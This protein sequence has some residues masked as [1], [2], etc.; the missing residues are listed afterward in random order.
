MYSHRIIV[1]KSSR[2]L[3]FASSL[4]AN[5]YKR[6]TNK[7]ETIIIGGGPIGTSIALHLAW[8]RGN[9][10]GVLV[11]ERD[12][13]FKTC[14][15]M[16]S[17][18]GIRQQ[19][20]A[21][22][23]IQMS[24]Y[25][26]LFLKDMERLKVEDED[27]PNVQFKEN[28]YLFLGMGAQNIAILEE[29]NRMQR[30]CGIDWMH[31]VG[32][33]ELS[34][35][36]PWLNT[37][38]LEIGSYSSK[39]EGYFD[40]WSLVHSMKKK[41]ISLGVEF[42]EG[43]VVGA[44]TETDESKKNSSD[45]F[46][47]SKINVENYGGDKKSV[48]NELVADVFVNAAGAWAGKLVDDIALATSC[49]EAITPLPVSPRKRCIFNIHCPGLLQ[50]KFPVPPINTP[51]VIDPSGVYFRPEGGHGKFIAGVSPLATNDPN[52][53]SVMALQS[54]DHN[55]FEEIIWPALFERVPAFAELKVTSSWAGFYE[56]NTLDQNCII[57]FHTELTNLML[58]NGFSGHG[59]QQSPAAGRAV[60]ELLTSNDG[61][62][63]TIDLR[64]FAFDRVV[65]NKPVFESGIV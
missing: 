64:A 36:F 6:Q 42:R 47:I 2:S 4:T 61:S 9:G 51:L 29:N 60:A 62:F 25:G 3:R 16:L 43:N 10:D 5:N 11:I 30:S 56:Y 8:L 39:N 41:A 38:G 34:E 49:S 7:Y 35:K 50:S 46:R 15:A 13:T 33:K 17:A 48:V 63:E 65:N 14:S 18:G 31:L 40:P 54:V 27:V 37:N 44:S 1:A 28:G 23:N 24:M 57:G 21:K 58:C 19:F 52:C 32:P 59:L 22:E 20:S 12:C 55:L 53:D 26:A 45:Q